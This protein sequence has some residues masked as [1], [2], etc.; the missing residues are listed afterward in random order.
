MDRQLAT[1]DL[2]ADAV[3]TTV[4][5]FRS[6][7]EHRGIAAAGD[8]PHEL[9][10]ITAVVA[11]FLQRENVRNYANATL[12]SDPATLGILIVTRA[13]AVMLP[14][15]RGLTRGQDGTIGTKS[16]GADDTA[17]RDEGQGT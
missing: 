4:P 11:T 15:L 16:K 2:R 10:P 3:P 12:V 5:D 17:V 6:C 14:G 7:A 1:V 8:R 9:P 13:T